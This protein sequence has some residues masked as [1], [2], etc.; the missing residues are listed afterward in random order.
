MQF[1][2]VCKD[3]PNE[4]LRYSIRS[5]IK[6]ID[7]PEI[8]LVGGKPDW[9]TG[10]FIKVPQIKG[11][12]K[13][14]LN[15]L[16]AVCN[17]NIVSNSFILMNDDFFILNKLNSILPL[18]GG[19]LSDKIELY[20]VLDPSSSYTKNLIKLYNGLKKQYKDP[21]DYELHVPMPLEK[22]NVAICLS[23][24][25][26]MI[27]RSVYGNMFDLGGESIADVKFY[28]KG[29]LVPKSYNIEELSSPYLSSAPSSF[30]IVYEKILKDMFISKT[31]HERD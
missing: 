21:L 15:N 29:P 2:Y 25:N 23:K 17:S 9:Y 13:N 11:K 5:V 10:N 19:L 31:I 27:F 4:E 22:D 16:D 3:G 12:Y 30:E 28:S 24:N 26:Q 1:V 18:N 20:K 8:V 7:N 6:H 14:V